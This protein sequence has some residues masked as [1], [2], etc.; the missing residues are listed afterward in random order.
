MGFLGVFSVPHLGLWAVVAFGVA[1]AV[2]W[3]LHRPLRT[4]LRQVGFFLLMFSTGMVT[5]FKVGARGPTR[6]PPLTK[7]LPL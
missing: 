5:S 3:A 1:L 2:T 7:P 4:W 6:M